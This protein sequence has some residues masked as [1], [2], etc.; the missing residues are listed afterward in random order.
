MISADDELRR[1]LREARTIAVVGLSADPEK[2]SHEV[3]AYLQAQG[4]R[5]IPVNPR[6]GVILGETVYADLRAVPEPID[7]VDVFRPA[8]DCLEVAREAAAVRAKAL[9]LQLGIVND[10]AAAFARAAGLAVV[11]D[12]CTLREHRRLLAQPA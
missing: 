2:P 10:E 4:Y 7:L 8:A 5:I 11:M 3:A 6:G 9:W 1:I 12:R